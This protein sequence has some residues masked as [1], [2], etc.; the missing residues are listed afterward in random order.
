VSLIDLL[1]WTGT[2]TGAASGALQAVRKRFDLVGA[3]ILALVMSRG[4]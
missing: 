3:L 2:L 4:W 1:V